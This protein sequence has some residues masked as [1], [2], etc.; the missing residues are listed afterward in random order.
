[1]TVV[2]E[3]SCDRLKQ[4]MVVAVDQ[5]MAVNDLDQHALGLDRPAPENAD[6]DALLP[7]FGWLF[8]CDFPDLAPS[9]E[10]TSGNP[11]R[12][13]IMS[14]ISPRN[15]DRADGWCCRRS[16][17]PRTDRTPRAADRRDRRSRPAARRAAPAQSPAMCR[18]Y[19]QP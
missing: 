17:A 15:S 3:S 2:L 10:V 9:T 12:A 18:S 16:A 1:M 11:A 14:G 7:T 13:P 4:R 8:V 19:R 5:R 6:A